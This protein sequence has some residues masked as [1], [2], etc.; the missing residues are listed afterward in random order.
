MNK[1]SARVRR[2]IMRRATRCYDAYRAGPTGLTLV[3]VKLVRFEAVAEVER[4]APVASPDHALSSAA[5]ACTARACPVIVV[6]AQRS[7]QTNACPSS[8]NRAPDVA[9]VDC[10][11][12][13]GARAA[14]CPSVHRCV[15]GAVLCN[16]TGGEVFKRETER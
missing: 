6:V 3:L 16:G 11:R 9:G 10:G 12:G 15:V 4:V 5:G 8:T 14:G 7:G 1:G 2:E 13:E